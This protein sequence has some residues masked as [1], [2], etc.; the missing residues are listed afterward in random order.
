MSPICPAARLP[1]ARCV[2][3]CVRIV[4][5]AAAALWLSAC[6]VLPR[7]EPVDV[8]TLPPLPA[9][10]ATRS[11]ATLPL[12]VRVARPVGSVRLDGKALLVVPA[13]NRLSVYKGARW[14]DAVPELVRARLLE[15]LRVD[16]RIAALSSDQF[17][18]AADYELSSDLL[19]FQAEYVGD[20]AVE[21]VFSL[22]VRLVRREGR[23]I[24]AMREFSVRQ[25]V[26]GTAVEAVVAAFGDG[27]A[28]LSAEVVDWAVALL[29]TAP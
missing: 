16:G 27:S 8:F 24:V 18:L 9:P 5:L 22:N 6:S 29:E 23:R 25:P 15:A 7:A 1:S 26:A 14:S 21:A 17:R 2:R 19:A 3:L 13:A 4:L 20:E 28:Q 12:T 11:A 10:A